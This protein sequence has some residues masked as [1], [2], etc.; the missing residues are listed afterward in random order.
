VSRRPVWLLDE[1]T[2]ALDTAS[3]AMVA[4]LITEHVDSGGIVVA[5]THL[6]LGV[7]ARELTF[8]SDGSHVMREASR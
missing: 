2:A 5:A 1:P 6:D 8:Q 4:A 7:K 3:Q